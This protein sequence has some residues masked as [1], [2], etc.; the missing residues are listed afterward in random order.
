MEGW[1]KR[2]ERKAGEAAS[3]QKE[4]GMEKGMER[5]KERGGSRKTGAKEREREREARK[6][7]W[8]KRERK[9]ERKR[10][11]EGRGRT[12]VD[13]AGGRRRGSG[14]ESGVEARE[15]EKVREERGKECERERE[16]ALFSR[17]VPRGA[18]SRRCRSANGAAGGR[19]CAAAIRC[20]LLS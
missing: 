2:K 19:F 4:E 16:R 5:K 10:G 9:K 12:V 11:L 3:R 15:K 17:V 1:S 18:A 20:T 6:C 14:E 13:A 7:R 8:K